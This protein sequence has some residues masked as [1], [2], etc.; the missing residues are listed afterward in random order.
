MPPWGSQLQQPF[1]AGHVE[2]WTAL[3]RRAPEAHPAR[4]LLAALTSPWQRALG[5]CRPVP[6]VSF[7]VGL[8]GGE[9]TSRRMYSFLTATALDKPAACILGS[10]DTQRSDA[11]QSDQLKMSMSVQLRSGQCICTALA[12]VFWG[13]ARGTMHA[14][15]V[16]CLHVELHPGVRSAPSH[17]SFSSIRQAITSLLYII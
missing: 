14:D 16:D 17:L 2:L 12:A 9:R 13:R 6:A 11:S 5:F 3:E 4:I 10:T 8:Q 1:E 7:L 15:E